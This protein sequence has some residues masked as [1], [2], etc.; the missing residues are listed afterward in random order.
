M[1]CLFFYRAEMSASRSLLPPLPL[2]LLSSGSWDGGRSADTTRSTNKQTNRTKKKLKQRKREQMKHVCVC[3]RT[4][5][6]SRNSPPPA[7][8]TAVGAGGV[9]QSLLSRVSSAPHWLRQRRLAGL[10]VSRHLATLLYRA[11]DTGHVAPGRG[12]SVSCSSGGVAHPHS[13]HCGHQKVV[14]V[15][16]SLKT[17]CFVSLSPRQ[18]NLHFDNCAE[19]K[20][21]GRFIFPASTLFLE[22]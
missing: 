4:P 20:A 13:S 15:L 2:P 10:P 8:A 5:H 18:P 16:I 21:R 14:C 11:D 22:S 19:F 3:A 7:P 9:R 17:F 6:P 12:S 1:S